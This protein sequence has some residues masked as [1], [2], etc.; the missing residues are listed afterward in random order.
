VRCRN[1]GVW[2][3]EAGELSENS[4]ILQICVSTSVK[5][6]SSALW[7][8]ASFIIGD[9]SV[10]SLIC[11]LRLMVASSHVFQIAFQTDKKAA[12]VD[13]DCVHLVFFTCCMY[14]ANNLW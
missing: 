13:S 11:N 7:S 3:C 14:V 10:F 1:L 9:W 8:C 5:D 6:L 12:I 2:L 4:L